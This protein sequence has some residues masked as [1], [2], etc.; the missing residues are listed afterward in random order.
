MD[1]ELKAIFDVLTERLKRQHQSFS[2]LLDIIRA[3]TEN[4]FFIAGGTIRDTLSGI[5]KTIKDIDI[6]L[7]AEGFE[8]IAGFL[9]SNGIVVKNQ[10][11]TNR[12]FPQNETNFYY[13]FIPIP[14]FYNGLWVCR[15]ITDALNQFDITANAVAFDLFNGRFYNPQ[16][17]YDDIKNKVL[18]AIRFDFPELL[19]SAEIDISRLS[20]LWF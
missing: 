18:R 11:G 7:T 2:L 9:S 12:W 20:V 14:N 5:D 4:T 13:D 3:S 15:D 10:F 16:N 6:L 1:I 17:G 19:V 8:N